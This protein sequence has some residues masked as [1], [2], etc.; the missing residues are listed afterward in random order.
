MYY[1]YLGELAQELQRLESEQ[2]AIEEKEAQKQVETEEAA[3]EAI[4]D[5][6][7]EKDDAENKDK[8][9]PVETVSEKPSGEDE[10]V[11]ES[12]PKVKPVA[13]K[14]KLPPP[15]GRQPESNS[16]FAL[17]PEVIPLAMRIELLQFIQSNLNQQLAGAV[18]F[19]RGFLADQITAETDE[20]KGGFLGIG[21]KK[22]TT[23]I[24]FKPNSV[25]LSKFETLIN[26]YEP[27]TKRVLRQNWIM[28]S[29]SVH[30]PSTLIRFWN[31][32]INFTVGL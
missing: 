4:F 11:E 24:K 17:L 30:S 32:K 28:I 8:D 26:R 13:A 18:E 14:D 22:Q 21:N 12:D 29:K 2:S 3:M 23:A 19:R 31:R 25:L 10:T 15:K 5:A 7:W 16:Q 9:G 20:T 27:V 1:L 6:W